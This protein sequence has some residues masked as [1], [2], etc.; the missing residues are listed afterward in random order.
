MTEPEP[1]PVPLPKG[2]KNLTFGSVL[3]AISLFNFI[4]M[5]APEEGRD[6][7]DL[8]TGAV[9][10]VFILIGLRRIARKQ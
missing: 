4:V 2:V 5:T 8:M 10:M 6:T 9:G 1:K 3:L 7:I